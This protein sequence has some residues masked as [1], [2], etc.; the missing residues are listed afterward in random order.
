MLDLCWEFST[1]DALEF[2]LW[3]IRQ[4]SGMVP[5]R[6]GHFQP[7][8]PSVGLASYPGNRCINLQ[9]HPLPSHSPT[10]PS[11]AGHVNLVKRWSSVVGAKLQRKKILP[12]KWMISSFPTTWAVKEMSQ[13]NPNDFVA[14]WIRVFLAPLGNESLC[15]KHGDGESLHHSGPDAPATSGEIRCPINKH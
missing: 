5:F 4:V 2:S 9:G 3:T 8:Q 1:F 11:N 13:M 15:A 6:Y 14:V 12:E 10:L 7:I